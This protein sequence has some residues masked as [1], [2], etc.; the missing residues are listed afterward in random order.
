MP[1]NRVRNFAETLRSLIRVKMNP[2]QEDDE[3]PALE[4]RRQAREF[5]D[6]IDERLECVAP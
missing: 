3:G 4:R 1:A 2:V 5:L 6:M